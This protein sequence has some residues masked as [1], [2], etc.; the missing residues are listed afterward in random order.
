VRALETTPQSL[1]GERLRNS[2]TSCEGFG[3]LRPD[4]G[5]ARVKLDAQPTRWI[6]VCCTGEDGKLLSSISIAG[7]W[8]RR[9]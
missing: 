6:G 9:P 7:C 1:D 8:T 3:R 4:T 2:W 5:G